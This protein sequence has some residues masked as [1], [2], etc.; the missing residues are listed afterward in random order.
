[1]PGVKTWP[2]SDAQCSN[3]ISGQQLVSTRS[4]R[5]LD[6]QQYITV[7]EDVKTANDANTCSRLLEV[8]VH[9]PIK[10]LRQ[11]LCD[12]DTGNQAVNAL[13]G[14]FKVFVE[15]QQVE[16]LLELLYFLDLSPDEVRL[17]HLGKVVKSF[18]SHQNSSISS[19]AQKLLSQWRYVTR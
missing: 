10:Q 12:A 3:E 17:A 13:H 4:R 15:L 1:M 5:G 6:R 2:L 8:L 14:W 7:L 18:A 19:A 16:Q 9:L 11:G